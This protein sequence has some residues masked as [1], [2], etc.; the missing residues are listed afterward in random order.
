MKFVKKNKY[1]LTAVLTAAVIALGLL[2]QGTLR[3]ALA[4]SPATTESAS[5]DPFKLT[6]ADIIEVSNDAIGPAAIRTVPVELKNQPMT[7]TLTAKTGLNMTNVAHVS[8]LFGGKVTD[9]SVGLG[10]IVKGPGEVGGPTKLC[11]IESNDLAQAKANWLQDLIQ[12]K[13][14]E[15]ALARAKE[16]FVANVLAEKFLVDAESQLMKDR[17]AQEAARQQLLIFGLKDKEIDEIRK[18]AV[19]EAANMTSGGVPAVGKLS[20]STEEVRRER[21]GYV[22]TAPRGGVVAEKFVA[23]GETAI[24]Q[25]N[26][27]TIADT[28]TLWIWGDVYERDLSRVKV[29]QTMNVYFTSEPDRAR[30]CTVDWI[31]PVLDPNTHSI[32]IRGILDNRDGHLLSDMYGTM[33][34]TV[35]DGKNSMIIPADAVVREDEDAYV[36]VKAGQGNGKVL[37]RR[38]PVKLEPVDVGFGSAETASA[39]AGSASRNT[40]SQTK[41]PGIV[42]IAEGLKPGDQIVINGGVGLFNEMKEQANLQ[43]AAAETGK[44]DGK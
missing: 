36:F 8:A 15:Q 28:S 40:G 23:G 13:I 32:K 6:G 12:V 2:F 16:L 9:I 7:L 1:V 4:D 24:P 37:F 39:A 20:K 19:L 34:I 14:D 10:D 31:S 21:M 17:S 35:G 30:Q 41:S 27:F 11:V 44:G 26:L 22:L 3:R 25:N 33:I 38:T 43:P 18:E 42:R 5:D 29:G